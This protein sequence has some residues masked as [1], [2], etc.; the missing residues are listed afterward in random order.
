MRK[1]GN[2]DAD[3]V[4]AVPERVA[5]NEPALLLFGRDNVGAR[6]FVVVCKK[7]FEGVIEPGALGGPT[8]DRRC[9][10]LL[11]YVLRDNCVVG[12]LHLVDRDGVRLEFDSAANSFAPLLFRF[13]HHARNQIDVD[14]RK[15]DF[16]CPFVSAIDFG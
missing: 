8:G 14:L 4:A 7:L 15:V 9:D 13:A 6:D 16:T 11:Q 10:P 1:R 3:H 5:I 2:T 12:Q